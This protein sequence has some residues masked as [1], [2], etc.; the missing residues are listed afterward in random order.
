MDDVICTV[1]SQ[2]CEQQWIWHIQHVGDWITWCD[3]AGGIVLTEDFSDKQFKIQ[4]QMLRV[5]ASKLNLPVDF[6][7]TVK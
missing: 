5:R 3:A 1:V 4:L 7:G 2:L 6:C